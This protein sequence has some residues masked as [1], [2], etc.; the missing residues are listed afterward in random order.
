[1]NGMSMELCWSDTDWENPKYW[2][3]K[4]TSVS[5]CPPQTLNSL[6]YVRTD[7]PEAGN[8][9]PQQQHCFHQRKDWING[10]DST[11]DA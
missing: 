6:A 1:M 2:E 10:W 4:P 9:Q 3:Q 8:Y 11:T 7:A 5:Q